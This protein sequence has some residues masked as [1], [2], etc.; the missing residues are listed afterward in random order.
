L[1]SVERLGPVHR[2]QILKYLRATRLRVGILVNFN[3][4]VLQDGLRRIIL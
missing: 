2:A 3:V 1:K 4:A